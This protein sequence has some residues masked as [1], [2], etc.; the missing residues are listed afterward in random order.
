MGALKIDVGASIFWCGLN[1][2]RVGGYATLIQRGGKLIDISRRAYNNLTRN[3]YRGNI[4]DF[5]V[6]TDGVH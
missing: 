1:G 3:L 2:N 6:E 5:A 4:I